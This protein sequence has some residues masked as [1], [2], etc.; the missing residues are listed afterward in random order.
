MKRILI[1]GASGFI[2]SK[3]CEKFGESGH[4]VVGVIRNSRDI[5]RGTASCE[6]VEDITGIDDWGR[7]VTDVDVVIHLAARAHRVR[8]RE[9]RQLGEFRRVN[10]V[11]T[12]ALYRACRETGVRRFVLLSSIGVHGVKSGARAVRETD[13][14]SPKEPYA[15]S[16]WEAEQAVRSMED[17]A[18]TETVILRPALVYGPGAKGNFRRLMQLVATGLPL[19]FGSVAARRSYLGLENLCSLLERCAFDARAA[20]ETFAAAEPW[21]IE[22]STLLRIMARSMGRNV[23]LVRVHPIVL[24]GLGALVGRSAEVARLTA[25]FEIDSGKARGLLNWQPKVTFEEEMD[26]MVMAFMEGRRSKRQ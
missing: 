2:G 19:P 23:H 13:A 25:P 1:T 8:E 15:Q 10:V 7:L 4:H 9:A 5:V 11:P 24:S 20:G 22:L 26:N 21:A 17:A 12:V 3:L 16:K 14:V 18:G 6:I